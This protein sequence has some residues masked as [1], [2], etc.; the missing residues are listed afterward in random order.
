[1][2]RL[3]KL[4]KE[5]MKNLFID[6]RDNWPMH[7]GKNEFLKALTPENLEPQNTL[8]RR[9]AV[10]A[11]C[12]HC[13]N[14]YHGGPFDCMEAICPLYEWMPY[15]SA[16]ARREM[17]EEERRILADRL[18]EARKKRAGMVAQP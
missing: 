7:K 18:A 3:T 2:P 4:Q 12:Y 10:L 9:E 11:Q 6:V 15:R 14:G 1:M 8:T 17:P 13:C 16:K 5:T